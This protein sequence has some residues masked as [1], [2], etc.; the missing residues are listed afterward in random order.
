MSDRKASKGKRHTIA[1][2]LG[3]ASATNERNEDDFFE[4]PAWCTEALLSVE[5]VPRRIWEPCSGSGSIVRVLRTR[6]FDVIE[7][8][9]VPRTGQAQLD[10]LQVTSASC[11]ALLT[12]PPYRIAIEWIAKAHELGIDY[13]ALLLKADF[14]NAKERKELCELIG[15]PT[16]AWA[17]S[18]RPDFRRQR[19]P[20]MNC[21]WFVW[22]GWGAEHTI[23][24][25]V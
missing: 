10:F 20:C 14:L 15:Y 5:D 21:T 3:C 1:A 16:R 19:R 6:G 23:T 13:L 7:S 11:K 25:I 12:N 18:R 24:R 22:D 2:I 17:L 4:T 9:L 8:D